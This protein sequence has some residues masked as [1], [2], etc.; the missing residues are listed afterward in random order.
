MMRAAHTQSIKLC[1]T[2][3]LFLLLILSQRATGQDLENYVN[4]PVAK[5]SVIVEDVAQQP[6]T[7]DLKNLLRVREGRPYS[8]VEARR[9]L[10]A[11]YESGRVANA[12][13]EVQEAQAGTLNVTFFV[14]PQARIGEVVFS[15]LVEVN[16]DEMR[17]KLSEMDRG[18]K[19][20]EAN[21][22]RA[23][24]QIY[25]TMR[26]RGYY[27]T[28]VEPKIEY[29][30][31]GST[32]DVT[33]NIITGKPATIAAINLSGQFKLS[34]TALRTAMKTRTGVRFSRTQL[35]LDIQ[36]LMQMHLAEHYLSAQIG[37]PDIT[38]NDTENAI[39]INLPV[40][41]GP[42]FAV[43]V[44]GYEISEKRLKQLLPM[45]REGGVDSAVLDDSAERIRGY[46]QEEGYFFAEVQAPPM[47]DLNAERA[48]IVFNATPNERYRVT[49]I[50]LVGTTH[51]KLEDI[52]SSLQSQT[53]AYIPIPFFSPS[54]VR[55]IT[56]EQA[57]RHDT[58]FILSQ[59][60][61]QGFRRARMIS[62]ARAVSE[63]ND[64]LKLIFNIEEG[65]R[66]YVSEIVFRGNTLFSTDE[67]RSHIDLKPSEAFSLSRV[68]IEANKV[69]QHYYDEG[70]ASA[71]VVVRAAEIDSE[72]VRV[73]Y[74]ISEGPLVYINRVYINRIGARQRTI[75]GRVKNYLRFAEGERL[76]NDDL[77]R[78]EQDL[79]AVGAFRRA[80]IY[81]RPLG[82]EGETGEVRR[83]VFVDVE[84]GKSRSVVYG[85][86]YQS[87]EGVRGIFE[88]SDPNIFGRLTTISLRLRGS[89]RNLL[90]QLAYTDQR[91]FNFNTP[92]LF[93]LL[94]QKQERPAFNSQRGTVL[95][96]IERQLNERSLML[97]RYN[98]EDVRVT[99]PDNVTD[100]RDK[101]VRLSRLSTSY[102]FDGRDNP[103]DAQ[104]GRYHTADVS[105]ALRA[106]GGNEQF[107]R[108]F[109]ENQ[110]YYRVPTELPG[111]KG[112]V[113]AA[114]FRLGLAQNIG[115]RRNVDPNADPLDRE[116]LPLTER[117]FSG[118]STTL[119]GFD[120]EEAGP[121]DFRLV[122]QTVNQNGQDVTVTQ[123]V[124]RPIGGNAL[125]AVNAEIRRAIYRQISLVGF[126]DGGNVFR[127]ISEI[128][129]KNFSHTIGTG[130]RFKTP[131]G[132]F[133]LD[134]G[135]LA[136]NPYNGSGLTPQQQSQIRIPRF[137][138]H[139]SFGQAF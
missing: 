118:G 30:P 64:S 3:F 54:Y 99:N 62:V 40:R 76:R 137:Q 10:L 112:T 98:Y 22:Q 20:S 139:L 34:E 7:E 8:A 69:L 51:L 83:D 4:K 85:A 87:D 67:L 23:A 120:F 26:D 71:N 50:R 82:E 90:G 6:G 63:S 135:Y 61:D 127:R 24:E 126:Y 1:C 134:L 11:L 94:A 28:A 75:G 55:G 95:L 104:H 14:I 18:L 129:F 12:R 102:A 44:A 27:Q 48:E 39:T 119:R 108:F 15:G 136:S 101:P 122:T 32:A 70:Y 138:I 106:L 35:N 113:L 38:Y 66:S 81:S 131:L 60:R 5:V 65:P 111:A 97:F 89:P 43:K 72:H 77:A 133:R 57:I 47:P 115:L 36:Q 19:F 124:S 59:L 125:V 132:P 73:I 41:T 21:V 17:A 16:E 46:L 78:S 116:L 37:P 49:E 105:V 109:T 88:V 29:D 68:K 58:D 100:R 42:R 80:Q 93:S 114:N 56:S 123:A 91:P 79:Y 96:Q 130:V 86:G 107:V 92:L 31:T 117:F 74:E 84:E 128:N 25:E 53:A 121:R 33:F 2:L 103:F 45:L 52:A 13:V 110:F 9:S